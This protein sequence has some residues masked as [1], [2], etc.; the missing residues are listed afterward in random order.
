MFFFALDGDRAVALE[1]GRQ[2]VNRRGEGESLFEWLAQMLASLRIGPGDAGERIPRALVGGQRFLHG[3]R[4]SVRAQ[5]LLREQTLHTAGGYRDG[6]GAGRL[7]L[8]VVRL[9]DDDHIALRQQK[10][11]HRG[12][13]QQQGMIDDD[14]LRLP[15]ALAH[16]AYVAVVEVGTVAPG[17]LVAIG[18]DA[19]AQ[20]GPQ[21]QRQ[22]IEVA[23]PLV[24][25]AHLFDHGAKGE[26]V[27]QLLE[28]FFLGE[29]VEAEVVAHP[30]D[31]RGL[32]WGDM[33]LDK[34]DIFVEKLLLQ[35]FVGGADEGDSARANDGDEV[36]NRLARPVGASTAR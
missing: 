15:G 34:G 28:G 36:S 12:V 27:R 19:S 21:R 10:A 6:K 2:V 3:K 24:E 18:G 35:G 4:I 5:P 20:L 9:V 22:Q 1:T 25:V 32:E 30:L 7:F 17:A 13:E 26:V 8:Q 14:H 33:L 29:A 16:L 31:Q 23:I 11:L